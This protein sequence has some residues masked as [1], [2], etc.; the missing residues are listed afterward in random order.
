MNLEIW[1]IFNKMKDTDDR[2]LRLVMLCNGEFDSVNLIVCELV[3]NENSCRNQIY[4]LFHM[5]LT[6]KQGKH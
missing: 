3:E 4:K 1:K 5:D 2:I 6:F